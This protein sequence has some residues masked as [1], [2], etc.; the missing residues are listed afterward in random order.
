MEKAIS[1]GLLAASLF[2]CASLATPS[3][4][5]PADMKKA[6]ELY[7]EFKG[8]KDSYRFRTY[9]FADKGFPGWLERVQVTLKDNDLALEMMDRCEVTTEDLMNISFDYVAGIEDGHTRDRE[10]AFE[11]CR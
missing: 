6:L 11:R 5:H 2:A 1:V 8:F 10:M 7:A 9:G 4:G 3:V